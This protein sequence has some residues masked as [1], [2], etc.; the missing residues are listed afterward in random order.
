MKMGLLQ[1]R[2]IVGL[3]FDS[4][5]FGRDLGPILLE[6]QTSASYE[7]HH[8]MLDTIPIICVTMTRPKT[9]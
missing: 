7:H 8:F 4:A 9:M 6:M 3:C 5:R 1:V 2:L